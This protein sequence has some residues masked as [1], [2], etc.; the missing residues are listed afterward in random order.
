MAEGRPST[1]A[2][3]IVISGGRSERHSGGD[4]FIF[5]GQA[6]PW[7]ERR[8]AIS[9]SLHWRYFSGPSVRKTRREHATLAG[10]SIMRED[11]VLKY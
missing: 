11:E 3:V 2:V 6:I 8:P 4:F 10:V 5:S 1:D 9:D 7:G